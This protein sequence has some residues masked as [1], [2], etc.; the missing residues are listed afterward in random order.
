M[1][2]E[3]IDDMENRLITNLT[4]LK[5]TIR[6]LSRMRLARYLTEPNLTIE[7][8]SREPGQQH[9]MAMILVA[10][11]GFRVVFRVHFNRRSIS[12]WAEKIYKQDK[13]ELNT[14]QVSSFA[15]EYCNLTGGAIKQELGLH[16]LDSGISLPLLTRGFDEIFFDQPNE[17]RIFTDWWSL[18][19]QSTRMMCSTYLEVQDPG[20]LDQLTLGEIRLGHLPTGEIEDL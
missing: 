1:D 20:A 2:C 10:G 18:N 13:Q 17:M 3:I 14:S 11:T 8:Q 4:W 19:H 5:S 15:K 6:E 16:G 12:P 9:S 7:S